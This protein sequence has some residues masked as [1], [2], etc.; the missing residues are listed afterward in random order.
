MSDPSTSTAA[1]PPFSTEPIKGLH[2]NGDH[3]STLHERPT[4]APQR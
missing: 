2:S 4:T 3:S 1:A